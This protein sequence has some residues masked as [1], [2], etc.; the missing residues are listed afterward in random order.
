[1]SA[2]SCSGSDHCITCADDGIAMTVVAV[3]EQ[4]ALALC[5]DAVG[6]RQS[7]ETALVD[8]VA[9]GDRLLVH[10]GTAIVAL[11]DDPEMAR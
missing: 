11:L 10:A 5:V 4:R 1:M 6:A 8:P 3:D 9:V 2:G 7:V